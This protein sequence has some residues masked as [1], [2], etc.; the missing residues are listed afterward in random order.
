MTTK[1]RQSPRNL[2][3][4]R[5]T[6]RAQ[7]PSVQSLLRCWGEFCELSLHRDAGWVHLPRWQQRYRA[8]R[9]S[10]RNHGRKLETIDALRQVQ[11]E[12]EAGR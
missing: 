12:W 4:L 8:L 10:A 9:R 11:R 3:N 2:R 7:Y 1:R 5:K 6:P